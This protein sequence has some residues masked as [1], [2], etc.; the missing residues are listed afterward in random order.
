MWE[1]LGWR[2]GGLP[3]G[4]D[5]ALRYLKPISTNL[6]GDTRFLDVGCGE[7]SEWLGTLSCC[8]FKR[9][10]GADPYLSNA[11]NRE[12]IHYQR[13]SLD[14]VEGEFDVI[15][16][17]HS[18][19]HI[20]DQQATLRSAHRLL[21]EGGT[22]LIRIPLVDS[23]VWERYG[24]HWVEL[25]APRHIFL[26][27]RASLTKLAYETGFD[28][29]HMLHD[30]E[31]FEFAGSEQYRAG[32]SLTAPNSFW[33]NSDDNIFSPEDMDRFRDM[34]NQVNL[35]STGGRAAFFLRKRGDTAS[36]SDRI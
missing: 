21:A 16:F 14:Q 30:S 29:V 31:E 34:A 15:S 35:E 27:T 1:R 28:V 32:I 22:C 6:R 20:S 8:G 26:H 9:L 18:L 33:I 2:L 7:H 10:A 3:Y 23:L 11:G 13:A 19:E 36:A 5:D 24:V 25:D 17:H 4:A 12:G